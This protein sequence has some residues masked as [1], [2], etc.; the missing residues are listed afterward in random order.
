[1]A[2]EVL[3]PDEQRLADDVEE[4][5]SPAHVNRGDKHRDAHEPVGNDEEGD[6]PLPT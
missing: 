3:P 6:Q 5:L 2:G 4:C 1:M